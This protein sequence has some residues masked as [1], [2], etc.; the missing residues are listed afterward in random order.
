MNPKILHARNSNELLTQE[1]CWITE[2]SNSADDLDLSIAHVRVEPDVTTQWHLLEETKERYLIISGEGEVEVGDMPAV[3]VGPGD[4][5]LIP[6]GVRQRIKNTG[7]GELKFYAL[8]TPRYLEH[9]YRNLENE[10]E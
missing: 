3:K 6:A 2:N 10:S 8:C 5:V 7:G 4:I 1:R 9:N